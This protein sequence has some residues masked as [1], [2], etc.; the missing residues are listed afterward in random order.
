MEFVFELQIQNQIQI[1]SNS[2]FEHKDAGPKK[3]GIQ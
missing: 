1:G 3:K 2:G